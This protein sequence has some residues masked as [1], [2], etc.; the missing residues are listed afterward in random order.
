MLLYS[1]L[2]QSASVLSSVSLH[3]VIVFVSKAE[4]VSV[5]C[6]VTLCHCIRHWGWVWPCCLSR[7]TMLL[8]SSLRQGVTVLYVSSHCVI[9]FVIEAGC[10]SVVCLVTLCHCI[11]HWG[12]LCQCCM[13]RH[14]V[15]LYSSLR[16]GVT[17]LSVS[18]HYVIVLVSK[19]GCD[20][21]VCLVT[22]CYCIRQ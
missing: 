2:R 15:L 8:Y 10:V 6:L 20:S 21:V 1:S 19:V 5:V 9:V 18:L 17:V 11:R 14:T 22:L 4:C 12:R 3:C 13:S 16:Q 7:Y